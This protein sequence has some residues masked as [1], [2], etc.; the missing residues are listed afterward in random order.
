MNASLQLHKRSNCGLDLVK[1]LFKLKDST[2]FTIFLKINCEREH[3]AK[4]KRLVDIST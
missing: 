1:Q 4:K 3:A 2:F